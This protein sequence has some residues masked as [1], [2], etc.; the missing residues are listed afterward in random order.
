MVPTTP[1]GETTFPT[2][3]LEEYSTIVA[4]A[5][6]ALKSGSVVL[7]N[8]N[9]RPARF[10]EL[11]I[12]LQQTMDDLEEKRRRIIADELV[13]GQRLSKCKGKTRPILSELHR[14][15]MSSRNQFRVSCPSTRLYFDN[16]A[17]ID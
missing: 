13:V 16:R 2:K 3:A 9:L 6:T 10:A 7:L 11:T 15:Q 8:T 17:L 12:Q 1:L 14:I 4:A 5:Q